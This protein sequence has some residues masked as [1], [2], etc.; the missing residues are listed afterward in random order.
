MSFAYL[1]IYTGDYIRDTRHLSPLRHGVY[2][3]A[4]MFCW[5]SKGPMPLDEQECAGICNCRSSDEI[6]ALRYVLGKYFVKLE[7]GHYNKRMAEE[8]ARCESVSSKR[9][10]AG[11]KGAIAKRSRVRQAIAKQLPSNCQA[12]E[13]QESVSPSPSPSQYKDTPQP[14]KGES[15]PA[16]FADFWSEYPKKVG[17]DAAKSSWARK[18]KSKEV[19]SDVMAALLL[20]KQSE[21]WQKDG[22]R[23]IP[24]PST[25]LN[26]GRWKDGD[27]GPPQSQGF[28]WSKGAV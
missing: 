23:F 20:Q 26:Q 19:A 6:E 28:D 13:Q 24:N 8:V 21:Q 14:P 17:K 25:W 16:G 7:D 9:S 22:G 2:F 3:L 11:L 10:E 15:L 1:P 4:L 18:V 27:D 12:I 5:D